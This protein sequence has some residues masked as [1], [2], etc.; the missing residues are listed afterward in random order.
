LHTH[1]K[2]SV[3]LQ[4]HFE[5]GIRSLKTGT[6]GQNTKCEA[7]RLLKILFLHQFKTYISLVASYSIQFQ[8]IVRPANFLF[9]ARHSIFCTSFAH[10][11]YKNLLE[12][13]IR[14]ALNN[15]L[16]G[17]SQLSRPFIGK[18]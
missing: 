18:L 12:L 14:Q 2:N 9:G 4:R 7:V 16:G 11:F 5:H 8:M 13:L 15:L 17:V 3:P 6:L 10:K 1:S